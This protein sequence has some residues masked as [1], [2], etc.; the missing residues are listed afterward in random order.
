MGVGRSVVHRRGDSCS[1]LRSEDGGDASDPGPRPIFFLHG[2]GLGM[3]R[4]CSLV[5]HFAH[6]LAVSYWGCPRCLRASNSPLQWS[7]VQLYCCTYLNMKIQ[8]L[9]SAAYCVPRFSS[10]F[11][12]IRVVSSHR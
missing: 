8:V 7:L 1:S 3:V 6:C 4:L 2:V 12:A 9:L 5:L 10:A 11:S